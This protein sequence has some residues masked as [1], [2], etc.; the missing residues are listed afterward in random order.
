MENIGHQK[1][2]KE[3]FSLT[4]KRS[5]GSSLCCRHSASK[6]SLKF[7]PWNNGEAFCEWEK[8]LKDKIRD[9]KWIHQAISERK[10]IFNSF[11]RFNLG[12]LT[13]FVNNILKSIDDK[14]MKWICVMQESECNLR[15]LSIMEEFR[16]EICCWMLME[17][18][19]SWDFMIR[20]DGT[21]LIRKFNFSWGYL[22]KF[23]I[24]LEV[25]RKLRHV[26]NHF[27]TRSCHI[28]Y[29][30]IFCLECHISLTKSSPL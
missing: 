10:E 19:I 5:F 4:M 8:E 7:L 28:L 27:S 23:I 25:V 2:V 6:M 26:K 12:L 22:R 24:Y 13:I 1:T 18:R 21:K 30:G 9:R 3:I 16:N 20:F 29:I 15:I 14:I 11:Y 17:G